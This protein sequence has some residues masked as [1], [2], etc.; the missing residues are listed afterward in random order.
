MMDSFKFNSRTRIKIP[1][2][3]LNELH[4]LFTEHK[5][6]YEFRK[7]FEIEAGLFRTSTKNTYCRNTIYYF[8]VV[9][10]NKYFLA[11]IKYGF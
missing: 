3:K 11:K 2:A 1:I 8:K 4:E 5:W 6:F 9:D 7:S 10:K